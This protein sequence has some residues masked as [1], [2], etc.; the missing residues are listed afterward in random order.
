MN[1]P[2][3]KELLFKLDTAC[4]CDV[5]KKIRVLDPAIRPLRPDLK[6]F[7]S[8]H[9]VRCYN[10]YLTILKALHDAGPGEVLVVDGQ[11]GR[12]AIA[13]E[14]F[15]NEAC[16]KGMTGMIIDGY[17]RDTQ[18]IQKLDFPVYFRSI[19]PVSGGSNKIF[20]TQVPISCG[21][22]MI[23]PGDILFGDGDGV[24]A[25]SAAEITELLP[26]AEKIQQTED[27]VL[28][29]LKEGESLLDLLNFKEHFSRIQGKKA[30]KLEFRI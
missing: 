27:K 13:G 15:A 19:F 9:T 17:I 20:E 10:D 28:A 8:A 7:G 25:V 6:L 2:A 26:V 1:I 24:I 5:N 16:R 22:A 30:S 12:M 23:H 21:G 18:A 3:L 29:K 14:M 4:L 11:G